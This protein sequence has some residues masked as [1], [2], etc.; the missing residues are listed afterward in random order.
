MSL[1]SFWDFCHGTITHHSWSSLSHWTRY[2][3]FLRSGWAVFFTDL[4]QIQTTCMFHCFWLLSIGMD[5]FTIPFSDIP[6]TH[7][8]MVGESSVFV[9]TGDLEVK[10]EKGGKCTD[11]GKAVLPQ[12]LRKY[13]SIYIKSLYKGP[14][15]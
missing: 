2:S 13:K 10:R 14:F 6:I 12:F 5:T 1:K 15:L 11:H 7:S 9:R 4:W 8:F 3:S